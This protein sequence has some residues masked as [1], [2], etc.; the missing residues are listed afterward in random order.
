MDRSRTL[1]VL[2]ALMAL[3]VSSFGQE[4]ATP[5]E[6]PEEAPE[7]EAPP[8]APP[9]DTPPPSPE[10]RR[11]DELFIPSEEISA[12]EEVIFPVSI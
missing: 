3:S 7:A 5:E 4:S 6:A 10:T 12:D 2:L 9:A 8:A 1:L 11:L